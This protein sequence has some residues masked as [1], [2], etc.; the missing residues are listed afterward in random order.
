[1]VS[2]RLRETARRAMVVAEASV[3]EARKPDQVAIGPA[4][5][6]GASAGWHPVP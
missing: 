3:G 5:T 2:L 4:E 1:M 6:A